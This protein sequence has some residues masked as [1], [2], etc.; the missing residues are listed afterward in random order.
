MSLVETLLHGRPDGLRARLR[1]LLG[2]GG[3]KAS[4]GSGSG[5]S[6]RAAPEPRKAE[7]AE[8][9][10]GLRKEAPKDVTPPDGFE[11][12]LHREGLED[13][14]IIEVIV[15]GTAIAVAKVG[16]SHY[17]ISNECPHAQGP[18]GEGSMDGSVVTC[19]YHGWKFDVRDGSCLTVPTSKVKTYE[20]RLVGD[21]VCVRM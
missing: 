2:R 18:L 4:P 19:P 8:K 11:V 16:G 5:P 21:A 13:G 17:A 20:V 3:N 6:G 1:S 12:V 14:R 9:A 15:G 7:P 10:L